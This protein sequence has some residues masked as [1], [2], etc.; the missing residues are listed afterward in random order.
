M[1]SAM[2]PRDHLTEFIRFEISRHGFQSMVDMCKMKNVP[3]HH[4]RFIE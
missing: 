1:Q 4:Q 3:Q 2:H